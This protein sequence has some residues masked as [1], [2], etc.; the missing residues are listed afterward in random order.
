MNIIRLCGS[1]TKNFV[2]GNSIEVTNPSST[3]ISGRNNADISIEPG[4]L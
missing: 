1:L 3:R 4:K 2:D